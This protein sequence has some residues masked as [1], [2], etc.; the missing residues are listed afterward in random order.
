MDGA[1]ALDGRTQTTDERKVRQRCQKFRRA[2]S[3]AG[4]EGGRAGWWLDRQRGG[5]G[6]AGRGSSSSEVRTLFSEKSNFPGP[7]SC[8]FIT[9][10][11]RGAGTRE[12]HFGD[13]S[14]HISRTVFEPFRCRQ[15]QQ[16]HWSAGQLYSCSE[17]AWPRRH[18]PF[19]S[20][21]RKMSG[22]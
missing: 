18:S 17:T 7:L 21:D 19:L 15:K 11:L 16:T 3:K 22:F 8:F 4:R 2:G 10:T 20:T 13:G 14:T 6:R 9:Q 5:R 1:A 12:E